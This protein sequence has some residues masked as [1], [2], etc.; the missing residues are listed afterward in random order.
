MS[1]QFWRKD[2]IDVKEHNITK[3]EREKLL[4]I[5]EYAMAA[6]SPLVRQAQLNTN[7]FL[8][9]RKEGIEDFELTIKLLEKSSTFD[10]WSGTFIKNKY[11]PN[12]E[13]SLEVIG[14]LIKS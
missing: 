14:Q 12:E 13:K 10:Q 8:E 5:F 3:E 6:I 1:R 7:D 9:F 4:D 2:I 11:I